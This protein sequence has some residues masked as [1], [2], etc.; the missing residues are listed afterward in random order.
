MSTFED[1][2]DKTDKCW[3]WKGGKAAKSRS[4]GTNYGS[5]K[6]KLA[7][8]ISYETYNGVLQKGDVVRHSCDNPICVNPN[9]L[10]KGTQKDNV[11]DMAW[12][13][14]STHGERNHHAVLTKS[15][16]TAILAYSAQGRSGK[17]L[18]NAF[19]VSQQTICDITKRRS[20]KN[21][22]LD[23]MLRAYS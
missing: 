6:G 7:H 2:I 21:V 17:E 14:R 1:F 15:K 23:Y 9:H 3:L 20:W 8:R 5:Y 22:S 4:T 12:R 19:G 16:V 13:R 11:A 10:I 18:A